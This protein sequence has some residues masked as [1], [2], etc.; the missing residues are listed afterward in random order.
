[1]PRFLT[2]LTSL[3]DIE[4]RIGLAQPDEQEDR[5]RRLLIRACIRIARAHDKLR[6]TRCAWEWRSRKAG[7]P[8]QCPKCH[9]PYW[10]KPRRADQQEQEEISRAPRP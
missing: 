9:S 8:G 5:A 2:V 3:R 7:R 1:M 6:C 10:D 4:P